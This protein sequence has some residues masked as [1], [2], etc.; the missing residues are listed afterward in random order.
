MGLDDLI[1]TFTL[2]LDLVC[3]VAFPYNVFQATNLI[4]D[5]NSMIISIHEFYITVVTE[6]KDNFLIGLKQLSQSSNLKCKTVLKD[7][8]DSWRIIFPF[9]TA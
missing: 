1:R 8:D 4:I 3:L 2:G 5:S 7:D 9:L 6:N